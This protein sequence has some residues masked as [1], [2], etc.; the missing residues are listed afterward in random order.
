[1]T[2]AAKTREY[3]EASIGMLESRCQTLGEISLQVSKW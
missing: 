3:T 1:M 2:T